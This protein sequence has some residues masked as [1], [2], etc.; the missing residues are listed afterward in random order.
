MAKLFAPIFIGAVGCVIL[1]AFGV[2]QL[3]RLAWKQDVIAQIEARI[4]QAPVSLPTE[5]DPQRDR[6]LPVIVRGDFDGGGLFVLTSLPQTGP[7]H[8]LIS[9]FKTQDGRRIMVD[10]GWVPIEPATVHERD[11]DVEIVGNLHWPDEL[12]RWTPAPDLETG[13]WFARDVPSMAKALEAEPLLVVARSVEGSSLPATPVPV[14]GASIPNNH[15]GY[16]VQWFGLAA[17]WAGMTA[18]WIWR[19]HRRTN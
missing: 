11:T 16:A 3:Q 17:V 2:W 12:D 7:V 15:L 18:Y 9:T 10:R 1:T 5:T 13:I 6:F 14:S 8:R 19:I 4:D